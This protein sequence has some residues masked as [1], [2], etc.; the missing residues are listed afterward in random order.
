MIGEPEEISK[1]EDALRNLEDRT[2]PPD[3]HRKIMAALPVE[4]KRP[5]FWWDRS[6][7][8][9]MLFPLS[10]PVLRLAATA[11]CLALAFY[12]GTQFERLQSTPETAVQIPPTIAQSGSAESFYFLGRSLLASGEA[13]P[14][15]EAFLQAETI[16]PNNPQYLLWRAAAYDAMGDREGERL[17]YEELLRV[18]PEQTLAR[19]NLATSLLEDGRLDEAIAVYAQVL[20]REPRN[21]KAMYNTALVLHLQNQQEEATGAWKKF[22][23]NYRTGIAAQRAL[24]HLHEA[25]DYSYRLYQIGYRA[26]ILNQDRLLGPPGPEREMEVSHLANR[27]DLKSL[28]SLNIVTFADDDGAEARRQ[29]LDLKQAVSRRLPAGTDKFVRVSWFAEAEQLGTDIKKSVKQHRGL[30]IFGPLKVE[31]GMEKLI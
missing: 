24:R 29:A 25:G 19:I 13:R 21:E 4:K 2:P 18:R 20:A 6:R 15:L 8:H 26:V 27:I 23:D 10:P 12:G 3:L 7:L 5:W 16:R 1:I 31:N 22:L 14:A 9:S 30:L 11:A 17:S 28:Q